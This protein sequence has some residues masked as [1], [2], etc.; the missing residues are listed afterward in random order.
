[1]KEINLPVYETPKVKTYTDEELLEE[2]GA[3]YTG[4]VNGYYNVLG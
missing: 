1:M 3:A 4:Y 2:L